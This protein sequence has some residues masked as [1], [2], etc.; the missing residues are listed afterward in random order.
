VAK[1]LGGGPASGPPIV[2]SIDPES[3]PV[4][5]SGL[6]PAST[7]EMSSSE[8]SS[9]PPPQAVREAARIAARIHRVAA[10]AVRVACPPDMRRR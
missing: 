8:T 5:A 1:Q 6:S 2:A 4:P 3:T 7:L 10:G 9:S